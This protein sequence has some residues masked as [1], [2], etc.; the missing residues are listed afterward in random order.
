MDSLIKGF[1]FVLNAFLYTKLDL[2]RI[3]S[4]QM[5]YGFGEK[6]LT[7]KSNVPK[8]DLQAF[9]S[10]DLNNPQ[11]RAWFHVLRSKDANF[12]VIKCGLTRF[13]YD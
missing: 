10:Q 7:P 13:S 9:G 1:F 6:C 4:G 12:G 5:R 2:Y 8:F 3:P 11:G